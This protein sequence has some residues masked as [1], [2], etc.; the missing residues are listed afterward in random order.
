MDWQRDLTTRGTAETYCIGVDLG[1]TNLR[2]A[3][4]AEDPGLMDIISLPTR[5]VEGRERVIR[6]LC[7]SVGTLMRRSYSGRTFAGVGIGAPGPLELPDGV[8]RNPP[9]LHGW[10]GYELRRV[11]EANL[12]CSVYLESDAN[13][14]ALAE[15][16]LG[17]GRAYDVDS[18]CM[19][20]LGTG[21]GNGLILGGRIWHGSTGMGGEAGHCIVKDE[22]GAACGCGGFG[23]LEQYASATA[24]QRMA[25]ERMG[26]AAPA[27]SH[28]VFLMA[29]KA[30]R[31]A[32]SVFETVGHALAVGL[33][34][35]VNTLNLPLYLLGGGVCEAWEMFAPEM[36]R[37]LHL[38]SYVYR[39]TEP[40]E[41]YPTVLERHRT[42]ILQARLGSKAGLLGACLLPYESIGR[43][44]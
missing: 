43:H 41:L 8:L 9:N 7:E 12:G 16:R 37:E 32:H 3:S 22:G 42:Y 1:G 39:L 17:V 35:L 33:T 25:K 36:F 31:H 19:L 6:D 20:T 24:I 14:A 40:A 5:L 30:D 2:I 11:L 38:R 23:C 34:G 21:V 10:D 18:L 28:D 13:A 26:P 44:E 29:K 4:Y 27:S 15:A